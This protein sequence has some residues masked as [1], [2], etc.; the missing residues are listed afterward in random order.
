VQKEATNK[1]SMKSKHDRTHLSM[2][3]VLTNLAMKYSLNECLAINRNFNGLNEK[4]KNSKYYIDLTS[5]SKIDKSKQLKLSKFTENL[6]N[7]LSPENT[8]SFVINWKDESSSSSSGISSISNDNNNLNNNNNENTIVNDAN[9]NNNNNNNNENA[10]LNISMSKLKIHQSEFRNY[11]Q[12]FNEVLVTKIKNLIESRIFN[13]HTFEINSFQNSLYQEATRHLY[14]FQRLNE[15]TL[16][17]LDEMYERVKKLINYGMKNE[18]YPLFVY[19]SLASGKTVTLTKFGNISYNLIGVRSCLTIIRYFDLTSQ[20]STFEGLLYSICVQLT[21]L[22]K[23]NPD[24]E[25]PKKDCNELTLYFNKIIR[26]ISKGPKQLLILIDGLQ[27]VF[28]DKLLLEKTNNIS[29]NHLEWLFTQ[30]PPKVHLIVSVKKQQ[31]KTEFNSA[32]QQTLGIQSSV[33]LLTHYIEERLGNVKENYVFD[34]PSQIKANDLKDLSVYIKNELGKC[35][36][37]ISDEQ[38]Q[39]IIDCLDIKST[40][41]IVDNLTPLQNTNFMLKNINNSETQLYLSILIKYLQ[42]CTNIKTFLTVDNIPKDIESLIKHQI[43]EY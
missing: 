35:G 3:E 22:H 41:T 16:F 34:L 8:H 4:S 31:S 23:L 7:K 21:I 37:M 11:L 32:Y 43:G 29:N 9:N 15:K 33:S 17:G 14:K 38:L 1:T 27:D 19:G 12:N 28:V 2:L 10:G 5:I 26:Q 42:K 36:R 30:L 6:W 24:V 25:I 39:V 13:E 20:C 18:H 40:T